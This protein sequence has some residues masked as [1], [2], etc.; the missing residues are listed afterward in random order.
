LTNPPEGSVTVLTRNHPMPS[1]NSLPV[2]LAM[3]YSCDTDA[4][5]QD[6]V[7]GVRSVVRLLLP[8]VPSTLRAIIGY[9]WWLLNCDHGIELIIICASSIWWAVGEVFHVQSVCLRFPL[10]EWKEPIRSEW[11]CINWLFACLATVY[12]SPAMSGK[13]GFYCASGQWR[14]MK[15]VATVMGWGVA[16]VTSGYCRRVHESFA[17]LGYYG[18]LD[19]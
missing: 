14:G 7:D 8:A 16:D 9:W 2:C 5:V 15:S 4:T 11:L 3:Q 10:V 18:A 6:H 1:V 19:C 17:F 13:T 12:I